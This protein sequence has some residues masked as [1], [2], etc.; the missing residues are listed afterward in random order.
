MVEAG[1]GPACSTRAHL[2]SCPRIPGPARRGRGRHHRAR[3]RVA[4][5]RSRSAPR[6]SPC[7][8]VAVVAGHDHDGA[9]GLELLRLAAQP[10]RAGARAD[11]SRPTSRSS[12]ARAASPASAAWHAPS[13]PPAAPSSRPRP[14]PRTT[15]SPASRTARRCSPRSP[16][17]SSARAAT[18]SR[19]RRLHRHR[20][21]QAD[22]R[23]VRA[24]LRRR[25]AAPDR[26][27]SSPTRSAP[28]T[29]SAATA[30]RSSCSSCPRRR[31]RTPSASPRSC[32]RSS[33][34]RDAA[35]RRR[36]GPEGH[37]QHRHRRRPRVGAPAR[38]GRRPRRC[39]DVRGEVARPQP[40]LPVPRARRGGARAP[41]ADLGGS[42][43]A[44]HRHRA[45][46]ERH[47]HPGAR[48]GP[49]PAAASPR[50]AV[51]HDRGARDRHRPRDG[52][53]A[54]GDRAHPHRLPPP[55]PRQDR[56]PRGDPRQADDPA[57]TPSGRRS[58]SIHASAR[59]SS[60]RRRT[61][62]RRSRSSSTTTSASTAAA[63]RT[64]CAGNEIPLGARIVA[65]ADA[66]HAMVH[67]RPYKGALTHE[68]ALAELRRHAGTQFDPV[69]VE[70]FCAIYDR[71]GAA[72]RPRGGLPPPRAG[73]W[74]P[75][76]PRRRQRTTTSHASV[77]EPRRGRA[78]RPRQGTGG[79]RDEAVRASL[80][81]AIAAAL[82]G[83]P[84]PASARRASSPRGAAAGD[85]T[86]LRSG[87]V[88]TA[89]RRES[90]SGA[91]G[92]DDRPGA[93]RLAV[94]GRRR[95]SA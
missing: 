81:V 22:Q 95:R 53:A 79:G 23:H 16:P 64:A 86:Q 59:S 36:P 31:R 40:H 25:G 44:G 11:A 14:A 38:H 17:R 80:I 51:G 18:T 4:A 6:S 9:P 92:R 30:A 42:P 83:A 67:D 5:R 10:D 73:A 32:A 19:W 82:W 45:V 69:V 56:H 24:Q 85:P 94:P 41:R 71:G 77:G 49:G 33:L 61:C 90:P 48:L 2:G 84:S 57:P 12:S 50:P 70:V 21:L 37:D 27:A 75:A 76:P 1:P 62:A 91:A 88:A 28:A 68:Q 89:P 60:S 58:A 87:C 78:R 65:V 39:G 34:Q 20:P 26:R 35:H 46:G 8:V 93:H 43:G 3:A 54:R 52:P 72:R 63:T 13:T 66:Y 29:R 55:R 15:A 7:C 74:R 47:R